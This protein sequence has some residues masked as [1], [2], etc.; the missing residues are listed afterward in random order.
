MKLDKFIIISGA[1]LM[2]ANPAAAQ[3]SPSKES[4]S[5][6]YPGKAYFTMRPGLTGLWQISDRNESS[7]ADRAK[8]DDKYNKTLSLATDVGILIATIG[9]VIRGTGY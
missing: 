8:F 9:V 1:I 3:I 6:L 2:L 4:L 7:F 5:G